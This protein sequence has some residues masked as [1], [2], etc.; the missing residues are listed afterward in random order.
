MQP[1]K[2]RDGGAGARVGM[3]TV[4]AHMLA[5]VALVLLWCIHFCGGL[6]LLSHDNKQ[7]IF[8][9][10]PILM[11]LGLIVATAKAIL[12]YRSLPWVTPQLV[13]RDARKKAH[14]ALHVVGLALGGLG[15]YAVF[16][17]P[18]E[19]DIPNLYSLHSWIGITTIS[20]YALHWLTAFFTFF[21]PGATAATRRSAVP[22][23]AL[24]GLLVFALAVGN[25]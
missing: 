22:W 18:V 6:A 24:L 21:F 3:F 19:A 7:P 12:C 11:L 8:N 13:S 16:K 23:H 2:G 20:L 25:A 5:A 4:L 9:A 17:F 15:I 10:H 14:L 1:L